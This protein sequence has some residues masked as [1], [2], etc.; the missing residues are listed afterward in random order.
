MKKKELLYQN[1]EFQIF[2]GQDDREIIIDCAEGKF[3]CSQFYDADLNNDGIEI[4][5]V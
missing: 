1:E 2:K 4:F 5:E 3:K